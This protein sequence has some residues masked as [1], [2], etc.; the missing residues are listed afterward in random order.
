MNCMP[1]SVITIVYEFGLIGIAQAQDCY[2]RDPT[3][4]DAIR[5]LAPSLLAAPPPAKDLQR[6]LILPAS[7][8]HSGDKN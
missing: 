6:P 2:T 1:R 8:A 7:Q 4:S 5:R 3:R